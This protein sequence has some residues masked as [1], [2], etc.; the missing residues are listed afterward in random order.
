MKGYQMSNYKI[1]VK[2]EFI[3]C[4]DPEQDSPMKQSDGSFEM[5]ID[6]ADA[7]SIDNC[8]T[9]ALRTSYEAIRGA[10]SEHLSQAS[11]NK[12]LEKAEA[13]I[14]VINERS[15]DV[16]GEAGRFHFATHGVVKD[17]KRVF[18]TSKEVFPTLRGKEF[19]RTVGFKELAY[20]YGDTNESFRKTAELI[21]RSRHQ[22]QNG[23]PSR[24]LQE[25]T[26]R[27]GQ[28]ILDYVKDQSNRILEQ[29]GFSEDSQYQGNSIEYR[30]AEPVLLPP[31]DIIKAANQ[32]SD[33][34][35]KAQLLSNPVGYEDPTTT[36]NIAIDDVNVKRQSS[37][38]PGE[39]D[40]EE[41][42]RKYAHNTI[43]HVE[44][45]EKKYTLNGEDT[46][47]VLLFVMAFCFSNNLIGTR[48]Q[49]FTDGH[50]L[51]NKAI[52]K[53]LSWYSNI[54]II[55]DWYHLRKKCKE[56]LSMGIRG[57]IIRN[58]VLEQLMPMLWH[59]LTEKAIDFLNETETSLIKNQTRMA[60]LVSYLERNKPY[61]P[62]YEIRKRLGLK[63][64]SAIGEKMNDL[65]VA[66]RQKHNGMSWSKEGSV[67][68]ASITALKR[69]NESR[70]WFDE[71]ELA[72][73][74]VA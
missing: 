63:N 66:D 27:E 31:A 49:F 53:A 23:T 30:Q 16:D 19:Y 48:L 20:I 51:L 59:G 8:E 36:T 64:S 2:V 10:L 72:F 62:C 3:E 28:Q 60:E 43:A 34:L 35:D 69:N 52:L 57:R 6:E 5:S 45:G 46:K 70:K 55:L 56:K 13:E 71:K 41:Q 24:T 42:K 1:R 67:A 68:L 47:S 25:S 9:A 7:I 65:V 37:S 38:R 4:N 15:Y 54:G 29:N 74:L 33:D 40:S 61:I 26:E 44:N 21:N 18:D 17:G 58:E 50:T 22:Q 32:C 12:A 11:K 39:K 14:I 73:R